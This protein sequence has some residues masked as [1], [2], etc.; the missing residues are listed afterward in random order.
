[1]S[2]AWRPACSAKGSNVDK[3]EKEGTKEMPWPFSDVQVSMGAK[4]EQFSTFKCIANSICS[5]P[6]LLS[7]FL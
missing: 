3:Q 1:M 5:S 4:L 7:I 2:Q 6:S